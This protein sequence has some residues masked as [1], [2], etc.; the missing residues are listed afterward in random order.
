MVLNNP[1][2]DDDLSVLPSLPTRKNQAP[3]PPPKAAAPPVSVPPPAPVPVLAA[4]PEPVVAAVPPPPPPA[5]VVA[6]PVVSIPQA[7]AMVPE[8]QPMSISTGLDSFLKFGNT[9]SMEVKDL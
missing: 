7:P 1:N 2:A 3:P 8:G 9:M 6:A 5:P 4:V